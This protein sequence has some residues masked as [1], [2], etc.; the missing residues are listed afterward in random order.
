MN[1]QLK[2]K[3]SNVNQVLMGVDTF[4]RGDSEGG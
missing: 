4:G 3:D 1:I 2:M